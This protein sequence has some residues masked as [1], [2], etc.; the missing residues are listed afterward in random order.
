M[1]CVKYSNSINGEIAAPYHAFIKPYNAVRDSETYSLTYLPTSLING[2][3][4]RIEIPFNS[5]VRHK[6][7]FNKHSMSKEQVK[8]TNG[9]TWKNGVQIEYVVKGSTSSIHLKHSLINPEVI[10]GFKTI[11]DANKAFGT[12]IYLGQSENIIYPNLDFGIVEMTNE[13]F[14]KLP[15]VETFPSDGGIFCGFNRFNNNKKQYVKIVREEWD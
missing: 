3:E 10:F 14:D 6:L 11:E 13:E 4:K 5:I 7:T 12:T 9:A 8:T 1:Y 15:G 2:I